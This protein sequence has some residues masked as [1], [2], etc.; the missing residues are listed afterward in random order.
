M[1]PRT[2]SAV[3]SPSNA[4]STSLSMIFSPDSSK[5]PCRA[6]TCFSRRAV[7]RNCPSGKGGYRDFFFTAGVTSVDN[8]VDKCVDTRTFRTLT[9]LAPVA[10]AID[11]Q[12]DKFLDRGCRFSQALL[13]RAGDR[14]RF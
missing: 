3:G 14:G 5:R 7:G 6:V 4:F 10:Q 2:R 9:C 8:P 12:P 1:E 11:G 13:R